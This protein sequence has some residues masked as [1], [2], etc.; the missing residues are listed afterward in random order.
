[1][2]QNY[3]NKIGNTCPHTQE[4]SQ[5][6]L[7]I[8]A[9]L[10][11]LMFYEGLPTLAQQMILGGKEGSGILTSIPLFSRDISHFQRLLAAVYDP[12]PIEDTCMLSQTKH[13]CVW[14]EQGAIAVRL[15]SI[16]VKAVNGV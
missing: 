14:A 11:D 6:N 8:F 15:T 9:R 10:L 5:S 16:Q 3:Q 4:H 12:F 2:Y 1:M 7:P 13:A